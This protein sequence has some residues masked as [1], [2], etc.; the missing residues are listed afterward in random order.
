M[1]SNLGKAKNLISEHPFQWEKLQCYKFF[2][3]FGIVPEG[4]SFKILV[5]GLFKDKIYLIAI[6]LVLPFSI[7]LLMIIL[8][9]D[10]KKIIKG[11]NNPRI[12]F[13]LLLGYY[14][15]GSVFYGQYQERYRMPLMVCFLI[16]YLAYSIYYFKWKILK[17]NKKTTI[18]KACCVVLIGVIWLY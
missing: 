2:R 14:I 18:L 6:L 1:L 3:F 12:L 15:V 9:S 17:I 7:M 13:M 4:S 11:I 16:P 5:T 8:L 10:Y